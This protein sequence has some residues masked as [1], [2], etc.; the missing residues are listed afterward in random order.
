MIIDLHVHCSERSHCGRA[1]AEEQVRAAI[2]AGLDAIA[3]TDHGRLA[4]AD[5][6]AR[7]NAAYAPFLVLG[8]IELRF[9]TGEDAIVLGIQDPA[10]EGQTWDYPRLQAFVRERGGFIAL[11]HP[12]RYRPDVQIPI[13]EFPPHAIEIRSNNTPREAAGRIAD[14]ARSLGA[15][16]LCNS[17]AHATDALGRYYNVL[18]RGARGEQAIIRA[19]R[20]GAFTAT[21]REPDGTLLTFE[22][23]E[24]RKATRRSRGGRAG[25]ADAP[26]KRLEQP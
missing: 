24:R 8:G 12:F 18:A 20:R 26:G 15:F 11:A 6:L 4:P 7:L 25:Q 2:A 10:L 5:E 1:T 17:D 21:A 23:H 16:V 19:L 9:E 13:A 14:L 22:Q 3:F